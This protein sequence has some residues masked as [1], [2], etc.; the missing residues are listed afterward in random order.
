MKPV[1][2]IVVGGGAAGFFCAINCAIFNPGYKII[3]LEKSSKLLS[4]VRISGGG[5]CNVTHECYDNNE[6]I[7]NYP[8]GS[9]ELKSAF[10]RFAVKDIIQWFESNNVK[11]KTEDDGRMFPVFDNSESIINCFLDLVQKYKIDIKLNAEVSD[12]KNASDHFILHLKDDSS[13]L[14]DKLV[15]AAGGHPKEESYKWIKNIGHT[16]ISPVPSLFTFNVPDS[17][18]KELMGI[19]VPAVHIKIKNT[20]LE[21]Q[22]P[23]LITHWGFSGPAVLKLS[24][25][26]AR[27]LNEMNY[28]FTISINWLSDQKP[29]DLNLFFN[30]YKNANGNK[31]IYGKPL[32]GLSKRLWDYFLGISG[33]NESVKWGDISKKNIQ[34]L[35]NKLLN[36]EYQV[37]GK[38]TF[39]EEF[40]TCGGISLKEVNFTTMESRL[41]KNMFFAGEVLDIDGITG[42]FNFQNAWT[43]AW[44]AAKSL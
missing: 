32:F 20:R 11:L 43:S 36:D 26:G 27:I 8:R 14:A 7:N 15:I 38:T 25:L 24:A 34:K 18:I 5:R 30:N 22:G 10:S 16:I 9:K 42:G 17:D 2:V 39:K 35:S 4:K 41:C 1:N 28:Q 44:I 29:D 33:I 21:S 23:L 3:I 19:S 13:L 12:V 6:L 40:V 37:S 31:I